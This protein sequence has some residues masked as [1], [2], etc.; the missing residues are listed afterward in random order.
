MLK[1]NEDRG[2]QTYNKAGQEKNAA[3]SKIKA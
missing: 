1:K 3:Y 2:R